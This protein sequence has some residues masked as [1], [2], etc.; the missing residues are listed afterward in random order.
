MSKNTIVERVGDFL[1]QYPPFNLLSLDELEKIAHE[2]EVFYLPKQE[3]LFEIDQPTEANFYIVQQGSI[4]LYA[5]DKTTLV[6]VC[7]TGDL[8]GLRP[9]F[10][11]NKYALQAVAQKDCMI[12]AIPIEVFQP[13][14][15]DNFKVLQ[16]LLEI[17][18]S[19]A[20]HPKEILQAEK[21]LPESRVY[22]ET[23]ALK[24]S[25]FQLISYTKNVISVAKETS[26]QEVAQLM[27]R[28]QIS[29]VIIT[30]DMLPK[31]IVTDKDMRNKV[32]TGQIDIQASVKEI[33][34]SPVIC[35][36]ANVHIAEIQLQMLKSNIGHICITE[37]GNP[38][39]NLLG[40]ISEH[41]LIAAQANNPVALLKRTLRS[42]DVN[43][44]NH[45]RFRLGLLIES[46][47]KAQLPIEY[48]MK[49]AGEINA[50]LTQK[51]IELALNEIGKPP[52]KFAWM[53]LGS[54]GRTEQL[55]LTDQDNALVFED[56]DISHIETT[57]KYFLKLAKK[58]T[59][60]LNQIGY[61][62]C[63]ADMMASNPN[64]CLSLSE[65]K[66][67]FSNWITKPT[68]KSIMMCSI[69]FDFEN[70]FGERHLT[71][72]I[73]HHIYKELEGNQRFYAYLGVDALRNPH[74]L[75]IFKQFLVED[76]EKNKDLFDLKSRAIMPLV[77]AAR[78]LCLA[79]K[80]T[81]LNNTQERFLMMAKKE[82]QNAELFEKCAQSFLLFS[83]H[84]T[85]EGINEQNSGRF[86]NLEKLSKQQKIA[87][88]N[89]F[90]PISEIQSV[91]KNRFKLTYFT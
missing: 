90:Q 82:P 36:Q 13:L 88:K 27:K 5:V 64:W 10:A 3:I 22:E 20:K 4:N 65:W 44:L 69:F 62:F 15:K 28:H 23:D 24:L 35:S 79:E 29:S 31:G 19:N 33:M 8:L 30:E 73:N 70:V 43:E 81:Q 76:S 16:F 85:I 2:V 57:R 91:L 25:Y 1:K 74:P 87:L 18:A 49:V 6:D 60:S 32:A 66:K 51:S 26:I 50:A 61:D 53:N 59:R 46:F 71:Q 58:V 89:A 86:I 48:L 38:S 80:N 72:S 75:G 39:S 63:P 17:F 84:R 34:S 56:V 77:D 55:L 7:E 41:D 40:I 83:K 68:E 78:I 54:L 12:Y 37:D 11:E 52:C 21:Q 47:L 42:K 14:L 67:Q 9:L 45:I